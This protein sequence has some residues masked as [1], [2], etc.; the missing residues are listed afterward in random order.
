MLDRV[1]QLQCAVCLNLHVA[2]VIA[3]LANP[4]INARF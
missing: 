2:V 4:P 1:A 3:K